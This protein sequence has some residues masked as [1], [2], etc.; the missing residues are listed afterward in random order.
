MET[1]TKKQLPA[2]GKMHQ[3]FLLIAGTSLVVRWLRLCTSNAGALGLIPRQGTTSP[4]LQLG[5][6]M[7]PL[8]IL[9][10]VMKTEDPGFCN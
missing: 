1:P 2:L 3:V 7:P 5:V 10:A 4:L 8:K 9:Y 6:H